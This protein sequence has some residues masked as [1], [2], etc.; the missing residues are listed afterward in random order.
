MTTVLAPQI[1]EAAERFDCFG[2]TCAVLIEGDGPAGPPAIA[3]ARVKRRLLEW[4]AQ[5]SRFDARSELSALNRDPR[6]HVPVSPMMARFVQAAVHAAATT[7]GLV[8]PTLVTDLERA[9][10]DADFT[11]APLPPAYPLRLAP[12]RRP[13]APSP[14]ARWREVSVD[15]CERMVSRP[16]GIRLD[17]GGIAKGLF[18]DVL[19][20][21]LSL[22]RSFAIAAAGDV[23]FGGAAGTARAIQITSPFDNDRLLHTFELVR[24]AAATSGTTRRSWTDHHGRPAHHLLDPA[25]GTPAFTG[26][27]QV[28]ALAPSGAQAEALAKAA[29]LSGTERAA[30]W[31]LH[32]GVVVYETGE[33]DVIEPA[34]AL[35]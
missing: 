16:A 11:Q 28:T 27:I 6:E 25:T 3:A 20:P 29:L 30:S 32:G 24:G 31:L 21:L 8:D 1:S 10:Y 13:G 2:G 9:G 19:A 17:S 4:H 33:H 34:E 23:R 5:F 15:L 35:R 14:H 26:V 22:H 7:G 18:G 12:A